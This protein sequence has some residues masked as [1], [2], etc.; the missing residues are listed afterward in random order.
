MRPLSL[1]VLVLFPLCLLGSRPLDLGSPTQSRER[2]GSA[3]E[4]VPS[5]LDATS[6]RFGRRLTHARIGVGLLLPRA[7]PVRLFDLLPRARLR[8]FLE[9]R[10]AGKL[11]KPA[12]EEV[13]PGLGTDAVWGH[14]G[15]LL[16]RAIHIVDRAFGMRVRLREVLADECRSLPLV[17]TTGRK[18]ASG[19]R[20][21]LEDYLAAGGLVYV[22]GADENFLARLCPGREIEALDWS[23]HENGLLDLVAENRGVE[24]PEQVASKLRL[25]FETAPMMRTPRLLV[26]RSGQRV[27]VIG[28][29][30]SVL[31]SQHR[32]SSQRAM[33]ASE[34][35]TFAAMSSNRMRDLQGRPLAIRDARREG[36]DVVVQLDVPRTPRARPPRI[37]A[38]LVAASGRT[39]WSQ[40]LDAGQH[41]RL[42]FPFPEEV[43]DPCAWRLQ[44]EWRSGGTV[45][46][47][48]RTIEGLVGMID[49]R[50]LAANRVLAG[51][52]WALRVVF[53][54]SKTGQPVAG[55]KERIHLLSGRKVVA[56]TEAMSDEN[57]T[58][59]VRLSIPEEA[60]PGPATLFVGSSRIPVTIQKDLRLSLVHDRAV[61]RETDTIHTRMLVHR[62]PSGKPAEDANVRLELRSWN[63]G[64]IARKTVKTS[65]FGIASASFDLVDA[66][67]G[68]YW[69]WASTGSVKA[70]RYFEVS[71]FELPRFRVRCQ[72]AR[73]ACKAGGPASVRVTASYV[74]GAPVVGARVE[75]P[76]RAGVPVCHGVTD[77]DGSLVCEFREVDPGD[78]L[79]LRILDAGSRAEWLEVPVEHRDPRIDV[80][81]R[82]LGHVVLGERVRFE[83]SARRRSD[84][85]AAAGKAR[86]TMRGR[87]PE[88]LRPRDGRATFETVAHARVIIVSAEVESSEGG[89]G[90][91]SRRFRALIPDPDLPLVLASSLVTR[92]GERLDIRIKSRDG[93]VMLD[94]LREGVQ[95]RALSGTSVRGE[96]RIAID[97]EED[98]A[99]ELELLA[100]R[101]VEGVTRGTRQRVFVR[102]SS[103]LEVTATPTAEVLRPGQTAEIDVRVRDEHGNPAAAALG[104]WAIDSALDEIARRVEGDEPWFDAMPGESAPGLVRIA[105]GRAD[106]EHATGVFGGPSVRRRSRFAVRHRLRDEPLRQIARQRSSQ[107][108]SQTCGVACSERSR[109]LLCP[110]SGGRRASASSCA[111]CSNRAPW[112][113]AS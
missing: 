11:G 73:V 100:Y 34:L 88:T 49:R 94:V 18:L 105:C 103:A 26:I 5:A 36:N 101:L 84:G 77:R 70:S 80:R 75:E 91:A 12:E 51:S 90:E 14:H 99:G 69:L 85:S 74:D 16:R 19:E 28:S 32:N 50:V 65:G 83:V 35:I 9:D 67:P 24:R 104:Y 46:R 29:R 8:K 4:K 57:G 2:S 81:I 59:D 17:M 23:R 93:P 78:K 113:A 25:A 107:R 39:R 20:R 86:I 106:F 64:P 33:L 102:R 13:E 110:S 96:A 95:V 89:K 111:T 112:P 79:R 6:V 71:A 40:R 44:L 27:C 54:H 61:Y 42:R 76:R 55:R 98:M 1:G 72:P 30:Q 97:L 3:A 52:T 37:E 10:K 60:R 109:R 82:R 45:L 108:T 62:F 53:E 56:G 21:L 48:S 47:A 92:V 63:H 87:S 38:R 43:L 15:Q 58:M 22:D 31:F 41:P 7:D 68:L 66:R